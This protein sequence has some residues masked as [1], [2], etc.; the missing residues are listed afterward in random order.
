[1]SISDSPTITHGGGS[2]FHTLIMS[3]NGLLFRMDQNCEQTSPS[4][5]LGETPGTKRSP[6]AEG[7]AA[8]R[9]S[10]HT[11]NVPYLK[12]CVGDAHISERTFLLPCVW[13]GEDVPPKLISFAESQNM[14]L[15]EMRSFQAK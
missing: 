14:T 2:A 11:K 15:F 3:L 4:A 7:A 5:V 13:V 9:S 8:M 1:M 12:L 6:K 10:L